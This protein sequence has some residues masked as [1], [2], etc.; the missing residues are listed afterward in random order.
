[1]RALKLRNTAN[2]GFT[3]ATVPDDGI[4]LQT[5][6]GSHAIAGLHADAATTND[7]QGIADA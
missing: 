7:T 2:D 6:T 1:V 5:S 3:I 4:Q